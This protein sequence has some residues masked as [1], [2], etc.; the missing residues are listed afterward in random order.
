MMRPKDLRQGSGTKTFLD[1][2]NEG[3]VHLARFV[4]DA[5]D[6]RIINSKAE[7]SRTLLMSA[8]SL[9]EAPARARFSQLLLGKGAEVNSQDETGRT[10]LSLAC[11]Q[12]YLDTVKLLVQFNADPDVCDVWGN[13]PLMYAAYAGH[14]QVLDFLVRAFKRMGLRLDRVNHSG[15][16]ALQVALFFDH[17]QCV[18]VLTGGGQ[19]RRQP[20]KLPKAVLERFS[21][22]IHSGIEELPSLL[23]RLKTGDSSGLWARL[24][25]HNQN[26][27]QHPE[28]PQQVLFTAKQLQNRSARGGATLRQLSDPSPTDSQTRGPGEKQAD[29]LPV[30][31]KSRSLPLEQ[32]AGRKQSYQGEVRVTG[33]SAS[34]LKRASLQDDHSLMTRTGH[35]NTGTLTGNKT[36]SAPKPLLTSRRK[37]GGA[38]GEAKEEGGRCREETA[39]PVLSVRKEKRGSLPPLGRPGAKNLSGDQGPVWPPGFSGLGS[40]LLRRF[41]APEF[42]RTVMDCHLGS[43][44]TGARGKMARSETFPFTQAHQRV[45]SQPSVDSISGVRCEFDSS[46]ASQTTLQ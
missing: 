31:G 45:H 14:S 46:T 12:G 32:L 39:D 10:A 11:E 37:S 4:L 41:T 13:S 36:T 29:S 19:E 43:S 44:G 34:R 2:M 25:S 27:T 15:H 42:L 40:R 30:W 8:V 23:N 33:L 28:T 6:G 17:S 1:A 21:R 20:N 3:K 38:T 18:Q 7:S 5:L 35:G 26:Q 24:T 9:P 22:P 16:S